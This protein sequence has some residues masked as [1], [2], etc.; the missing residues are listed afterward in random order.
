MKRSFILAALAVIESRRAFAGG[1]QAQGLNHQGMAA[2]LMPPYEVSTIVASMGMRPLGRPAWRADRYIVAAIDRYGREVNVVLDARDGQVI[3]VRRCDR[4]RLRSAQQR[5]GYDSGYAPPPPPGYPGRRASA[6]RSALRAPP[7]RRR[8]A[9]FQAR[10]RRPMATTSFSTTT[11]S[12][13]LCRRRPRRRAAQSAPRDLPTGSVPRRVTSL[14]PKDSGAKDATPMPRP[15]PALAKATNE[16]EAA[17][18]VEARG[19]AKPTK[20]A[21]AR[22][23]PTARAIARELAGDTTRKDVRVIDLSK[24]EAKADPKP[25]RSDTILEPC[26]ELRPVNGAQFF[27]IS[28]LLAAHAVLK[29]PVAG[30][31]PWPPVGCSHHV[32]ALN[33]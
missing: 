21:Q 7:L 9:P 12:R 8:P 22:R 1:A 24:P 13:V 14:S 28:A 5:S 26:A 6:L 10:R 3:A 32:G 29:P 20:A 4:G 2:D 11:A 16:S 30:A 33:R 19:V 25:R 23:S 27:C 31:G 17:S 18:A 15:R